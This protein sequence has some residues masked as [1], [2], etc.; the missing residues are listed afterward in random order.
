MDR[1]FEPFFQV[2]PGRRRSF[3]GAGLGL[4]IAKEIIEREGGTLI[5]ENRPEGGLRQTISFPEARE[6]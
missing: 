5:L 2:D 6:P 3:S 1:V 4:A